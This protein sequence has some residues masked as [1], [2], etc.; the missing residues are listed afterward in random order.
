MTD[1]DPFI[2]PDDDARRALNRARRAMDAALL[3]NH[4]AERTNLSALTRDGRG[5]THNPAC[6]ARPIT[7]QWSEQ[8][9]DTLLGAMPPSAPKRKALYL[10]TGHARAR[11]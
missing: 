10:T 1:L 11:P 9:S 5:V 6:A 4:V 8:A 3:R 7:I 2:T